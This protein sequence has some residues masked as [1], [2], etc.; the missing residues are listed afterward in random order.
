MQYSKD[1]FGITRLKGLNCSIKARE[2]K[3]NNPERLDNGDEK[4]DKH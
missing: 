1:N 4:Q 2:L 3:T